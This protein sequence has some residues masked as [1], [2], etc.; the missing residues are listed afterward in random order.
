MWFDWSAYN[1]SCRAAFPRQRR[2]R[3][4][5]SLSVYRK[6]PGSSHAP[7]LH[8]SITLGN[9]HREVLFSP[10]EAQSGTV[11][12]SKSSGPLQMLREMKRK[13]GRETG[14][15]NRFIYNTIIFKST[16]STLFFSHQ[17][18]HPSIVVS[19]TAI[20][21]PPTRHLPW[22][23]ANAAGFENGVENVFTIPKCDLFSY[24]LTAC[25]NSVSPAKEIVPIQKR[26]SKDQNQE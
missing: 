14:R 4:K 21:E 7:N 5:V 15:Q 19:P 13:K 9:R 20:L 23:N 22:R 25:L 1:P 26:Y 24:A 2:E 12:H 16:I 11:W 3:A 6:R 8:V 10:R 17:N 18:V